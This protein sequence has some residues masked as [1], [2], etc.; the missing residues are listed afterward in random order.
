MLG[1]TVSTLNLLNPF[2]GFIEK[3]GLEVFC[4]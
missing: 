2:S 4:F 3:V 1:G